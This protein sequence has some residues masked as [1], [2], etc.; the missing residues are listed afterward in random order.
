MSKAD[1]VGQFGDDVLDI[2]EKKDGSIDYE[3]LQNVARLVSGLGSVHSPA[4]G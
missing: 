4:A 3:A 1:I 2:V